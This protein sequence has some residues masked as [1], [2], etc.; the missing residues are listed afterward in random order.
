VQPA[1]WVGT[2][3]LVLLLVG[4]VTGIVWFG[5]KLTKR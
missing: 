5:L 2:V 3:L 1:A 4:L